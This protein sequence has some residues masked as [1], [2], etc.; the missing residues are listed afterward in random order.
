MFP[1]LKSSLLLLL[2]AFQ[3]LF[4][5]SAG[6]ANS[7]PKARRNVILFV[8]DGLRPGSVNATDAPTLLTIRQNGVNFINSHALF[9][10]FTTPNGSAI[11]TGHYLGDTGD[12]S[13]T[14][15]S[16]FPIFNSGNFGNSPGTNTPFIEND[17]ILG[18]L[19][20]HFGGNY[21][22]EETL[23]GFARQ[24]GYNTAAVG[25]LGP[26]AIQDVSEL[27]PVQQAFAVPTTVIIDDATGSAT[28]VPLP[29]SITAALTA[30]G[31]ATTPT[32]RVQ[33]SGNNTTPGTLNANVGQQQYF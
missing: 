20:D 9:P 10:T 26:V 1:N 31:L 2:V 30:A 8:A 12:F 28:G 24:H 13:N 33:P 14:I 4:F 25:K 7:R 15:F 27:N 16:G 11:A 21:L 3:T 29:A 23:L 19:D 32:P 18:D 17:P 6:M 5:P 22:G